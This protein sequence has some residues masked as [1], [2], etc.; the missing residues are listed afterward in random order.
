VIVI[1]LIS[2]GLSRLEPAAPTVDAATLWRDVVKRGSMLRQVR[3]LGTLVPEDIRWI[4]ATTQGRVEVIL[5]RPGTPVTPD[6]VI[7]ELSNPQLEQEVQDAGLR[8]QSAI[9]SVENLKAQL[10][11][12]ALQQRATAASIEADYNRAQMQFE[13]DQALAAK[14]LVSSLTLRSSQINAEQLAQRYKIAQQQVATRVE[15]ARAQTAVAQATVDQAR[16]S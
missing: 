9:A 12:D 7:L 15:S 16:T 5:L 14:Q 3:G 8:L 6:S 2:F 11:S 13:M 1:G 10:E 4:P